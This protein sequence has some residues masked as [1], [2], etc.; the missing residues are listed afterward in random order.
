MERLLPRAL[1]RMDLMI[2]SSSDRSPFRSTTKCAL[3][4]QLLPVLI[5]SSPKKAA[6]VRRSRRSRSRENTGF[7]R[8]AKDKGRP[9]Q[10]GPGTACVEGPDEAGTARCTNVENWLRSRAAPG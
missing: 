5:R 4:E 9:R 6:Q 8:E 2:S 10:G 1:G 3:S 7:A